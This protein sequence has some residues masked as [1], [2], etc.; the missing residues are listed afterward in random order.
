MVMRTTVRAFL[1]GAIVLASTALPARAQYASRTLNDPATGERFHIEA[2]VGLWMPTTEMG[3][4]SEA[5]GIQGSDIDFKKDLGLTDHTFK[6]LAL[7]LRPARKHKLRYQYI[8][9]TFEQEAA[10]TRDIVFQGIRYRA[11]IPVNSQIYWKAHRFTYEYDVVARNWGFVGFLLDAKYTDVLAALQ[12]PV[13]SEFI[14]AKAPVPTI[15]GIGRYYIVPN[16][17]ITG[18][19]SGF[20]LTDIKVPGKPQKVSGHY[21]ELDIY[22]T[23]NLTNNFGV[24][25][26]FRDL[27]V[28]YRLTKNDVPTDTGSFILKGLY[29]NAVA[30]F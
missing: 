30:R 28:G 16:I 11:T 26:G 24:Q 23:L 10:P 12:S 15:G 7:V 21:G 6:N 8:P 14:H 29:I 5:L 19:L 1:F 20:R 4:S 3:I 22:G 9:I 27:N 25:G 13:D 17:S 2:S 18:E